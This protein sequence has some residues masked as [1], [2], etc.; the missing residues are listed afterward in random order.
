MKDFLTEFIERQRARLADPLF[1]DSAEARVLG[2]QLDQLEDEYHLWLDERLTAAEAAAESGYTA[3]GIRQLRARGV[4]GD[5]RRDLPRKPG[6]G[7]ARPRPRGRPGV[8]DV[9]SIADR[10]LR[11]R[12]R[13]G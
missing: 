9:P 5:C 11:A 13:T 8:A 3:T 1:K 10:V 6:H 2:A 4:I 7:V 12:R